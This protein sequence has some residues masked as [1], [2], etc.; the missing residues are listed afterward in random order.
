MVVSV[1]HPCSTSLRAN[2]RRSSLTEAGALVFLRLVTRSFHVV[3]NLVAHVN[4]LR[5]DGVSYRRRVQSKREPRQ[6]LAN[7]VKNVPKTM[8]ALEHGLRW[9]PTTETTAGSHTRRHT[10][11]IAVSDIFCLFPAMSRSLRRRRRRR[12]PRLLLF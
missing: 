3:R 1:R 5:N 4:H 10:R 9:G 8:N 7:W 6:G 11:H 12:R 2:C